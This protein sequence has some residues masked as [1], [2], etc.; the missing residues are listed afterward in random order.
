MPVTAEDEARIQAAV[1]RGAIAPERAAYWRA[2]AETGEGD[3]AWLDV[4]VSVHGPQ[5]VRAAGQVRRYVDVAAAAPPGQDPIL[6]SANPVL[7]ELQRDKPALV[8]AALRDDPNPPRLFGDR[9]LPAFTS[10]GLDPS[11]LAGLPWPLR[12]P[13]AQATSLAK[14]YALVENTDDVKLLDMRYA[15]A[16]RDYLTAMSTWLAGRSQNSVQQQLKEAQQ[17]HSRVAA[18]RRGDDPEGYDRATAQADAADL[19]GTALYREIYGPSS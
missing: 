15:S 18:S 6:Y 13:V 7:A 1:Q 5:P 16:N 17:Q 9:D 12:R 8:A 10:S 4:M 19:V 2:L 11:V 14:A 3:T